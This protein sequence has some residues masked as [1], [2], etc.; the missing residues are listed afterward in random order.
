MRV[1]KSKKNLKAKKPKTFKIYLKTHEFVRIVGP[2]FTPSCDNM[3]NR[4]CGGMAGRGEVALSIDTFKDTERLVSNSMRIALSR[5]SVGLPLPVG[6]TFICS[7]L[8]W[9]RLNVLGT[10]HAWRSMANPYL[11]CCLA[12]ACCKSA[13]HWLMAAA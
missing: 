7:N 6:P 12:R 1:L 5:F 10:L 4:R 11:N 13:R 8:V 2:L 9:R 3:L